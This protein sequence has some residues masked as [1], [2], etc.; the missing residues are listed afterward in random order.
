[1]FHHH[2]QTQTIQLSWA[3]PQHN[4]LQIT[5]S[6][7]FFLQNIAQLK[8]SGR[9][10]TALVCGKR[11]GSG[12]CVACADDLH[13]KICKQNINA[14]SNLFKKLVPH[15]VSVTQPKT[16]TVIYRECGYE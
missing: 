2:L 10:R 5:S 8:A 3:I 4:H 6:L 11:N 13:F 16:E 12:S 15:L 14:K 1:M 9:H 7:N